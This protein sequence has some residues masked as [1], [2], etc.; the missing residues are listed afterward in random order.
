MATVR[1]S[2]YL[3][4]D[5]K[6][7]FEQAYDK[8]NPFQILS[9]RQ[10]DELYEKYVG[11]KI[12][13]VKEAYEKAFGDVL[14]VN[15]TAFNEYN[16]LM[17]HVPL[18]EYEYD[19]TDDAVNGQLQE[20]GKMEI[21]LSTERLFPRG[22]QAR[23]YG[24]DQEVF[25]ELPRYEDPIVDYMCKCV[26]YNSKC[27]ATKEK[28]AQE[29]YNLL[30]KYTTLNRALRAWPALSKLVDQ[31]KLDKVHKKVMRKREQEKEKATADLV[32]EA[33]ELNKVILSA[34]L[35]ED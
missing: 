4:N 23:Y 18:T 11:H 35:L 1:M 13:P 27:E 25:F 22:K 29:V 21:P 10:G 24:G 32:V 12:H 5:I 15:K 26:E 19:H 16:T 8:A 33:N 14:D 20:Y 34:S 3:R 30:G 31:D 28:K 2:D 7:A 9:P 17:A 6:K